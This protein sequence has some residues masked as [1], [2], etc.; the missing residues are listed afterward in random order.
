MRAVFDWLAQHCGPASPDPV[1]LLHHLQMTVSG[2]PPQQ[3]KGPL[4]AP[5]RAPEDL[6][7]DDAMPDELDIENPTAL[8]KALHMNRAQADWKEASNIV[9]NPIDDTWKAV[10][11]WRWASGE[12]GTP[13]GFAALQIIP[14]KKLDPDENLQ[15]AVITEMCKAAIEYGCINDKMER[16]TG[17]LHLCVTNSHM[18]MLECAHEAERAVRNNPDPDHKRTRQ[19]INWWQRDAAGRTPYGQFLAAHSRGATGQKVATLKQFLRARMKECADIGDVELEQ[20]EKEQALLADRLT[21]LKQ[22]QKGKGARKQTNLRSR[23]PRR[24][25]SQERARPP[26][27]GPP[28]AHVEAYNKGELDIDCPQDRPP[29]QRHRPSAGSGLEG[30]RPLAPPPP[31]RPPRSPSPRQLRGR[32]P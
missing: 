18:L 1:P 27:G 19:Y 13:A 12:P 21:R 6:D 16:G 31:Q 28:S 29:I 3:P 15:R 24:E 17:M 8:L 22:A 9:F 20:H 4:Q 10:L 25:W 32:W 30:R 11:R 7:D 26:A 23:L 2:K 5:L 14:Q